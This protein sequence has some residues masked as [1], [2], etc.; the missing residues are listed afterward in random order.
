MRDCIRI[1]EKDNVLVVLRRIGKGEILEVSIDGEIAVQADIPIYHK[2]ATKNI[3]KGQL[4]IKYGAAIGKATTDIKK[5]EYIHTHN[6][7]AIDIMG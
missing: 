6:L 5:G 1:H 7:D 3:Q 4:V 2:V